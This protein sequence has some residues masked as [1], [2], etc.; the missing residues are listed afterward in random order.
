MGA[1]HV[2]DVWVHH[3]GQVQPVMDDLAFK[4]FYF[5]NTIGLFKEK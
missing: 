1:G 4:Q 3:R 2:L 5:N